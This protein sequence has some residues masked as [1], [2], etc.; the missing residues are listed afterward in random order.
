MAR[1]TG[2]LLKVAAML[3]LAVAAKQLSKKE[4]RD[5]V[6]NEYNK[7]KEDPKGYAQNVQEKLSKQAGEYQE[8][9]KNEYGKVKED[10]KGYAQNVQGKVT[11]QASGYQEKFTKQAGEYQEKAKSEFNKAKEDPKGYARHAQDKVKSRMN[12][13]EAD[14]E[15]NDENE[16]NNQNDKI[17][18]TQGESSVD[19]DGEEHFTKPD[20][21]DAEGQLTAEQM[22]NE[23][24][25]EGGL[26]PQENLQDDVS[27]GG[28]N[29]DNATDVDVVDDQGEKNEN[30]NIHVVTDD[31]SNKDSKSNGN[32]NSS[33][34]NNSNSNN[35]K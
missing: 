25:S 23:W 29:K 31:D 15:P 18:P 19:D 4:N 7:V 28:L 17:S 26:H 34:S 3:G 2:G 14:Q 32:K 6:K 16:E 9:A 8:M 35:S 12:K 20:R 1:K 21:M 27:F 33:K 22:N 13:E 10:P 30:H 24:I 11:E 5:V